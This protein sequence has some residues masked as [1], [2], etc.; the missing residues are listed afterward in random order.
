MP[1]DKQVRRSTRKV[2][3]VSRE[4]ANFLSNQGLLVSDVGVR[5]AMNRPAL[6]L[7]ITTEGVHE[8]DVVE[9][10]LSFPAAAQL[11]RML[12]KAVKAYLSGDTKNSVST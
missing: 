1:T 4:D 10:A 2:P 3:V 6:I 11:A 8:A 9:L 7:E 5:H 12:K